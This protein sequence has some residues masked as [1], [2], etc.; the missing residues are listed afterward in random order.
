MVSL[1]AES[2]LGEPVAKFFA[3]S[4]GIGTGQTITSFLTPYTGGLGVAATETIAGILLVHFGHKA[5]HLLKEY[6]I[7]LIK[8]V[9]GNLIKGALGGA[10]GTL[11]LPG[12][13]AAGPSDSV[14]AGI[15]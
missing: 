5:H 2:I 13:A 12:M 3:Q 14:F 6:G 4:F 8:D 1:K 10:G 9:A 7:G 15:R 11:T